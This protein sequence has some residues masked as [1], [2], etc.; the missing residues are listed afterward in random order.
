MNLVICIS[1]SAGTGKSTQAKILAER[2]GLKY[3]SAGSIFRDIARERKM[4]LQELSSL[5]LKDKSIDI[6]IDKRTRE[7]AAKGNIVL[8]GRLTAWMTK[9]I[10]AFRAYLRCPFD[11]EIRRIAERDR[12]TIQEAAAETLSREKS[13]ETRYRKLYGI[14]VS[15]LTIYDIVIN[16]DIYPIDSVTKILTAAVDEYLKAKK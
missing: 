9:G 10:D 3:V 13:E 11:V 6:E 2:Y 16:T 1:G 14:D 8:E 12:K 7:L 4:S 15:D 5:V